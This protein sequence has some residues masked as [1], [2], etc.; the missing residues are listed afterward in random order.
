MRKNQLLNKGP[1]WT[2]KQKLAD[3]NNVIVTIT[4]FC[5]FTKLNRRKISWWHRHSDTYTT[6]S[7][8]KNA[9]D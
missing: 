2:Q 1:K 7:E 8:K 3:Q 6:M 4:V 9:L 5:M